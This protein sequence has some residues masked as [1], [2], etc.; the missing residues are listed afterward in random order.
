VAVLA[1]WLAACA[2]PPDEL[3]NRG[4]QLE[5]EGRYEDAVDHY[6]RALERAPEMR[7]A[8]G[9]LH[10][11]GGLLLDR[12][13]QA[14]G[15]AASPTEAAD[16]YRR[17]ADLADRT[18]AVGVPLRLP[19]TFEADR[20]A[21]FDAAVENLLARGA[22]ALD[23]GR[24]Q[25]ALDAFARAGHY[26]PDAEQAEALATFSF[27]THLAWAEADLAAGR[28]R[29]AFARA[30]AALP[31]LTPARTEADARDLQAAALEAGTV[32]LA[33]F[34]EEAARGRATDAMPPDFLGALRDVT[35]DTFWTRPPLFVGV[36]DPAEVR[37][38][39][40]RTLRPDGRYDDLR[41]TGDLAY[42]LGADLGVATLLTRY[43]RQDEET[44]RDTLAARLRDGGQARYVR[45]IRRVT[46][47]AEAAFAAVE[48]GTS[49]RACDERV[50][51]EASG[52]LRVGE[53]A[54]RPRDLVLD[55]DD[56]ALFDPE[57]QDEAERRIENELLAELAERLA[58]RVFACAERLVP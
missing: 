36:A 40:R 43:D 9:R 26:Q 45:S 1:G 52:R 29:S 16:A 56:R 47:R 10:V 31:F 38:L 8:Q 5:I 15:A 12:H 39:L 24:F 21:A 33:V 34:P 51:A 28:F 58:G 18:A 54:G 6:A 27:D 13:L 7:K 4:Q 11:V 25:E 55:R 53:Y 50:Q 49:R 3:Y 30:E 37:R 35:E 2:P 42:R 41:L 14:A 22:D 17:A 20:L 57:A 44:D 32:H 48:A 19:P 46:L 23:A